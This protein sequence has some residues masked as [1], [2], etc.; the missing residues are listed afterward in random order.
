[1]QIHSIISILFVPKRL[2]PIIYL[3][4]GY[5]MKLKLFMRKKRKE[6][7][8]RR[9][10]ETMIED[11]GIPDVDTRNDKKERNLLTVRERLGF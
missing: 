9:K 7:Y 4:N 6:N 8:N 2:D 1:M 10:R 5:T 3:I 11:A